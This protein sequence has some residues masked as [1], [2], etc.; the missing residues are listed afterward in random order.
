MMI[1]MKIRRRTELQHETH[2][3]TV[4]R[5]QGVQS[6]HFCGVCEAAV[7]H[8]RVAPAAAMLSLPETAVFRLAESGQIHSTETPAGVL[9]LCGNAIAFFVKELSNDRDS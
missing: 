8:L 3:L 4:I 9:M 7:V 1:E 5:Q 6:E 2:E